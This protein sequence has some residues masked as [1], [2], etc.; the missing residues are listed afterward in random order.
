MSTTFRHKKLSLA[1]AGALI[2]SSSAANALLIED[3]LEATAAALADGVSVTPLPQMNDT[4]VSVRA[5]TFTFPNTAS[6]SAFGNN[7]GRYFASAN[8]QG[9]GSSSATYSWERTVTND[10]NDPL[11]IFLDLFLYGGDLFVNAG[12]TAGYEWKI[13]ATTPNGSITI[14]DSSVTI[15]GTIIDDN[16]GLDDS[17]DIDTA[18]NYDWDSRSIS[19]IALGTLLPDEELTIQYDL[20]TFVD[21]SRFQ[22]TDFCSGGEN[23]GIDNEVF[24]LEEGGCFAGVFTGD[25]NQTGG[26]PQG[27]SIAIT[28]RAIGNPNDIPEP[29]SL[30][31]L[32]AGL[33]GAAATRRK[34]K[35]Q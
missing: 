17:P 5:D 7:A 22:N 1:I 16:N 26:V 6:A 14:L 24:F 31:L 2:A 21:G 11:N 33:M 10:E 29:T 28:P 15:N 12:Q 30:A 25:P 3:S 27:A 13:E 19:D 20:T 9:T 23:D 8:A 4:F 34:K 18:F 35:K 32:G